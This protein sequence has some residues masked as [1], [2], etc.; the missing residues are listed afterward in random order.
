[1]DTSKSWSSLLLLSHALLLILERKPNDIHPGTLENFLD[2]FFRLVKNLTVAIN[3]GHARNG[4]CLEC[5]RFYDQNVIRENLPRVKKWKLVWSSSP[6]LDAFNVWSSWNLW[7]FFHALTGF[8]VGGIGGFGVTAGAHRLWCH[9]AYKANVPLR[10]CLMLAYCTAGQV[11]L[12]ICFA[13]NFPFTNLVQPTEHALRLGQRPSSP[14]QIL[15]DWCRSAQL[16]SRILLRP[17]RLADVAET[18]GSH[19][20]RPSDRHERCSR[21]SS[22]SIPPEVSWI[23]L[24]PPESALTAAVTKLV[25]HLVVHSLFSSI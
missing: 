24:T 23:E 1:M 25:S 2:R 6:W 5:T 3:G 18:S 8:T 14:P 12:Q 4:A 20:E 22:H 10:I 9:R 11:K 15:G 13:E 19:Q 16:K 7:I 21:R 17:R